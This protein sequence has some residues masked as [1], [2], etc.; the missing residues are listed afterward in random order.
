MADNRAFTVFEPP[1]RH[2]C[3]PP[4]YRPKAEWTK[5]PPPLGFMRAEDR[6][7]AKPVPVPTQYPPGTVWRCACGRL[8][9]AVLAAPRNRGGGYAGGPRS[10]LWRPVR[11]WHR[12]LRGQ[13]AVSDSRAAYEAAA[14]VVESWEAP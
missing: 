10:V 2:R 14:Q 5:V 11:W 9:H 4:H 8:W 1:R 13:V 7:T 12:Q 6:A 3:S